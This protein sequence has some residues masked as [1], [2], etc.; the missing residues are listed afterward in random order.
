M[1]N[2]TKSNKQNKLDK[3]QNHKGRFLKLVVERSKTGTTEYNAKVKRIT[4][5]TLIFTDMKQNKPV[6]VL[7][8]SVV[9]VG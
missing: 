2:K 6:T 9:S 7:L 8:S 4:D 3:L 1:N 5:K